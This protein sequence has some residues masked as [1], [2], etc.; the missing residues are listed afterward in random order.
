MIANGDFR[1]ECG[2]EENTAASEFATIPT[3]E[4][5]R[6]L[7][8]SVD[9]LHHCPGDSMRSH[10]ESRAQDSLQEDSQFQLEFSFE[11]GT[12]SGDSQRAKATAE[13]QLGLRAETS[14]DLLEG[15]NSSIS[16]EFV[17]KPTEL[18]RLL[19]STSLGRVIS[20]RQLYRHRQKAPRI[21]VGRKRI[22]LV[23]YCGWMVTQR[24]RK[25][26]CKP[27]R[28]GN[29]DVITLGELRA[30]LEAQNYR[31]ALTNQELTP[32]NF[33]LDHIVPISEGGD[34]SAS[35]CHFVTSAVNR[36]KNTMS[37]RAFIEMCIMVAKTRGQ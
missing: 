27:R 36:A 7:A 9:L 34:F 8:S 14:M 33:A 29:L 37:E 10:T 2:T 18:V 35:N 3:E 23:A 19:N 1:L 16:Q 4:A 28:V 25:R 11:E 32:D 31:C 6:P 12:E 5:C 30:I 13:R 17:L 26:Q 21:E 15:K 24:H 20:E 22:D